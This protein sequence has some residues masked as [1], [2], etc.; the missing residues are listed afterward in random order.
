MSSS[1][2]KSLPETQDASSFVELHVFGSGLM[3][4]SASL[5]IDGH[6]GTTKFNSWRSLIIHK[7]S[8]TY[9]WFDMGVSHDLSQYPPEIQRNQHSV[10]KAQ[11]AP[12]TIVEDAKSVGVDPKTVQYL[13]PRYV[14]VE[15][16]PPTRLSISFPRSHAHW[17]HV[18]PM[19]SSFPNA[20]FLCGPGTLK[21]AAK[22]WPDHP[23]S[24]F[25][26]RIWNPERAELPI[27]EIPTAKEA[28]A[29]WCR[30]GPFENG[31]DFFG[32]GSLWLV[33]APG[34]FPGNL[35]ALVRTKN[36]NGERRWV[37]L[38][39][40]CMHCYDLLHYPEAPFGKGISVTES[41]TLHEDEPAARET[42]RKIA[43][44][45][46]AY[47]GELF[48]WPAHVDCLEGVWEFDV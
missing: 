45:R 11:P 1:T 47:D 29:K 36:R 38:G 2:Q 15:S 17:D 42:I 40:D 33:Q 37:V 13:I 31:Y 39:G 28:P 8:N 30:I 14:K 22:S 6:R 23:D 26:G 19:G 12:N 24:F 21:A 3:E 10:F 5:T 44:L 27:E 41:G 48:V 34:H 35:A 32:D 18:Y 16:N 43:S 25:D 20:K 46:K 9:L 4:A 7:S